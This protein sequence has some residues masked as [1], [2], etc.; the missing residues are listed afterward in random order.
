M[1]SKCLKWFKLICMAVLA[2]IGV[3]Q[4][5]YAVAWAIGNG[6]NIQDF[7]DTGIY[8]AN[9]EALTCDGW[10]LMGYSY[11]LRFF[12]LF[13]NMLGD[14][15]VILLYAVQA[16]VS[17]ACFAEGFRSI[18]RMMLGKKMDFF[19]ALLPAV[20][21]VTIPVIWQLQFAVLP[22]AICLSL[23]V[24]LFAKATEAFCEYKK[25][26]WDCY[27]VIAGCLL[28]LGMMHRHYFYGAILLMIAE[29]VALF[30]RFFVKKYR[31]IKT[32]IGA[33]VIIVL[34]VLTPVAVNEV[35]ESV[36][37]EGIYA[38]YSIEADLWSRFVYPNLAQDYTAYSERVT[39]IV[40]EYAVSVCAGTYEF[41]MNSIGPM[42]EINNPEEAS[43]IYREMVQTGWSL[44]KEEMKQSMVK[45]LASYLCMPLSMVKYM[46]YSGVSL[47]GHNYTKMQEI[48][49]I[50]T[51]DYMHV[52]M[53]GFMVV[54]AIGC[55]MFLLLFIKEK[56]VRSG[57]IL[58]GLRL[59]AALLCITL[60]LMFFSVA[61]F[62][63]RIG[64]FSVFVWAGFALA[65]I[66]GQRSKGDKCE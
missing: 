62:D 56:K 5:V 14:S 20:Y 22:D 3:V 15:Y 13:K 23:V 4:F 44:H 24:L 29:A 46:Y 10:R 55:L 33:C 60:P 9:A 41:Y 36:P 18:V 63:Y 66:C 54:S 32:F 37:K 12:M 19:K 28:L 59:A 53:N 7:Y 26:R 11:I 43:D 42:I 40:N 61:R 2:G 25:F 58:T 35:N 17:V 31:G 16:L 21:I 51:A 65:N 49:P 38:A 27:L 8:L 57:G 64:L 52:S 30:S 48:N 47:Y 45:E 50:L 34:A 39:A 1:S 6:S